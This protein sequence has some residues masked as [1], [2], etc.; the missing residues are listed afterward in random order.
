MVLPAQSSGGQDQEDPEQ[1]QL[2]DLPVED[3]DDR[4]SDGHP[5]E[6]RQQQ[7]PANDDQVQGLPDLP[8]LV[9]EHPP[10]GQIPPTVEDDNNG[11]T[12]LPPLVHEIDE[13][14]SGSEHRHPHDTLLSHGDSR[15]P[16][17]RV[18][19][20]ARVHGEGQ[21][22]TGDIRMNIA[23]GTQVRFPAN[24]G[25]PRHH[26]P[27]R[28]SND[29]HFHQA[30]S[31]HHNHGQVP[32]GGF[33]SYGD[34]V[35]EAYCERRKSN[36]R[37][38]LHHGSSLQPGTVKSP[39]YRQLPQRQLVQEEDSKHRLHQSILSTI[40]SDPNVLNN[41]VFLETVSK[42]SDLVKAIFEDDH[43]RLIFVSHPRIMG[44]FVQDPSFLK[45]LDKPGGSQSSQPINPSPTAPIPQSTPLSTPSIYVNHQRPQRH[46][47]SNAGIAMGRRSPVEHHQVEAGN[48]VNV[49][50]LP[51]TLPTAAQIHYD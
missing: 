50:T 47:V 4:I 18:N 35:R 34:I 36:T 26:E 11:N 41:D 15:Y 10:E 6:H 30:S 32:S 31:T 21:I 9:H 12:D 42:D 28:P 29:R 7:D 19:L 23:P 13:N 44:R 25:L 51:S 22:P 16:P 48:M 20:S 27:L 46:H 33:R 17:A 8:Q 3:A 49:T 39:R 43:L 24:I 45:H 38:N 5:S 40:R 2:A 1:H 14:E 37:A